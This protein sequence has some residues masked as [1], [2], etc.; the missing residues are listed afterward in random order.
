MFFATGR[1]S[2]GSRQMGEGILEVLAQAAG[3][4]DPGGMEEG[5]NGHGGQ[6]ISLTRPPSHS[7]CHLC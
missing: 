2:Q 7:T 1:A 6:E 3:E 5:D 4:G